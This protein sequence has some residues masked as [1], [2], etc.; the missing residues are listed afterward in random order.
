MPFTLFTSL[1]ASCSNLWLGAWY[2]VC[3]GHGVY[4][5][6]GKLL[7]SVAGVVET[8]NKLITVRLVREE[9]KKKKHIL[10]S[11]LLS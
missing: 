11:G 7:A 5:H 3:R 6:E 1:N 4:K 9:D 8:V 10:H 2:A